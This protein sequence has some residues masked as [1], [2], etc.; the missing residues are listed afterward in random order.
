M[1]NEF[2]HFKIQISLDTICYMIKEKKELSENSKIY[3][4][5]INKYF[6][7]VTTS[8]DSI[9]NY[10]S[11]GY[12]MTPYLKEIIE[13]SGKNTSNIYYEELKE[14]KEKFSSIV[15]QLEELKKDSKKYYNRKNSRDLLEFFNKIKLD[16]NQLHPFTCEE[17]LRLENQ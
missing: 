15:A 5:W 11:K 7:N 14:V 16:K 17:Y 1:E 8:L 4:E 13:Y 6:K 9:L 3:I 12:F 2:D 10:T